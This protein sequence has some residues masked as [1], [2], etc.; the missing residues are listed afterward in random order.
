MSRLIQDIVSQILI[1][2]VLGNKKDDLLLLLN[3]ADIH[4]IAANEPNLFTSEKTPTG[5]IR[6]FMGIQIKT[7]GNKSSPMVVRRIL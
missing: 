1:A 5:E 4:N 6:Y 2:L 3:D 7:V